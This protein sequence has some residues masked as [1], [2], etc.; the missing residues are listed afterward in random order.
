MKPI[1]IAIA[2]AFV[3]GC[4]SPSAPRPYPFFVTSNGER[5]VNVPVPI[6]TLVVGD[7]ISFRRADIVLTAQIVQIRAP[8]V[9]RVS[10]YD[11]PVS[12]SNYIGKLY[13]NDGTL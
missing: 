9:F 3:A 11:L 4:S 13:R 5:F 2:L 1:L 7:M 8:G 12:D 10:H 6:N